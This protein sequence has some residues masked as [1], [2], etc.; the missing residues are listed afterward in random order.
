MKKDLVLTPT[1]FNSSFLSCEKDFRTILEKLFV[2]SRPYSDD[3]KR[4]LVINTRDCLDNKT[5]DVY[6]TKIK[7]IDLN[8]LYQKGYIRLAPKIKIKE[9]EEVKSYI[10]IS[11]DNFNPTSNPQFRDCI[12]H[13]DII[14]H[15]DY[16]DIGD[17]R[18]RPIKIAGY[19]DGILNNAKLSGIG[20][21]QFIG[22][23]QLVLN[24]NFSGY[25]LSYQAVHGS[26]DLIPNDK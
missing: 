14:C 3:I 19:I 18:L 2:V 22:L 9:H 17:F 15:T 26:D 23:N 13:F 8:Q 6:K 11:F 20:T 1:N 4:L 7:E 24:E 16:W 12:V 10:L 21:L 25:T 5:S